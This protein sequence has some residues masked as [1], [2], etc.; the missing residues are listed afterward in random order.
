MGKLS[1]LLQKWPSGTIAVQPWFDQQQIGRQLAEK[2]VK[3]GW[4]EKIGHGAY[5]R[6]GETIE[7]QGGVYALQHELGLPI[8]VGG[9]TALELMGRTHFLPLGIK[10]SI[11]LYNH[12]LHPERYLPGWFK[13]YFKNH[14]FN[15]TPTVLFGENVGLEEQDYGTFQI[16]ISST[17]RALLEVLALI[18]KR[19]TLEHGLLLL[20]GKETLRVDL[21]QALLQDCRSQITKR[22]FL[23]LAKR[24]QLP[25]VDRLNIK[26]LT[27]GRGKR[28]IEN[29]EHYDSE[30]KL[31]VP[32]L[33]IDQEREDFI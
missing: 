33:S 6:F 26:V 28:K 1:E 27:L 32:K 14:I 3:G 22:L 29:G 21:L 2:Y 4:V 31:F 8:H 30:F 25:W 17:E 12:G 18:P 20:Q 10:R 7:W 13:K 23:Y 15:Y 9:K 16:T 24:C 19:G 5:I 11:N